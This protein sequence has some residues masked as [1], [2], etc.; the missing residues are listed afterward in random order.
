MRQTDRRSD[1]DRHAPAKGKIRSRRARQ[2]GNARNAERRK[3]SMFTNTS[4]INIPSSPAARVQSK[5]AVILLLF[6]PFHG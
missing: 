1:P 4:L 3:R 5:Y 2:G 6:L